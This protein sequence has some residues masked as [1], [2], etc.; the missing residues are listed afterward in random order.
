MNENKKNSAG[1]ALLSPALL[2]TLLLAVPP[3]DPPPARAAALRAKVLA[4]AA[5]PRPAARD[6]LTLRAEQ[7]EWRALAPLAEMK[8]LHQDETGRSFLLRLH[9][10]ARLP[11]HAHAENEECL[12]LEGEGYI[13]D[14]FL[15]AGDFHLA[16][17]G[18]AH[19]ETYTET[20]ALLYIRTA[21]VAY[22]AGA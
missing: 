18:V 12:V 16:P 17:K 11:P 5:A 22:R 20:G 10:G 14:I 9:P 6:L 3:I 4:Q 15:R 7:G 19:G 21:A 8:L 1:D 2:E 13:G